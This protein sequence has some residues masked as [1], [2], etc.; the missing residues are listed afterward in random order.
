[1]KL[2]VI[3]SNSKGNCYVL[4]DNN[5]NMLLIECGVHLDKIKQAIN[6]DLKSVVGVLLSHEHN[7]H[8]K[9]A[10][11]LTQLG[12]NIYTSPGTKQALKFESR[13]VIAVPN[14]KSFKVGDFTIKPFDCK[15]DVEIFGFLIHHEEMGNVL[16]MTDTYYCEYMFNDLNNIIIEANYCENILNDKINNN[17][18]VRDRVIQSH[19]SLQTCIKTLNDYNLCDVNNIVVIHLSDSNSDEKLFYDEIKKATG[20]NVHIADA[21]LEINLDKTPF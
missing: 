20:K 17:G 4:T 8:C 13:N 9:S 19:M 10:E 1:M 2:H 18:F 7:D 12:V 5:G 3:N 15:H 14:L 6:F 16:F 21:G 11:Q